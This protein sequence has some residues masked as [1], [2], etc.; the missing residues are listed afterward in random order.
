MQKWEYKVL[1]TL[2]ESE[3]NA[4]GEEGWEALNITVARSGQDWVGYAVLKRPKQASI[5][6]HLQEVESEGLESR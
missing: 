1:N 5:Q 4:L 6:S 3:L 2:A